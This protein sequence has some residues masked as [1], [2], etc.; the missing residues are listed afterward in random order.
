[1]YKTTIHE[2]HPEAF[3]EHWDEEINNMLLEGLKEML[4]NTFNVINIFKRK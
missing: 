1:V 4:F 3:I 2:L